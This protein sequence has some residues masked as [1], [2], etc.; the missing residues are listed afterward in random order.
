MQAGTL[1]APL[2]E[3]LEDLVGF[4]TAGIE[5]PTGWSPTPD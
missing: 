1:P 3:L 4:L 5:A 2:Y